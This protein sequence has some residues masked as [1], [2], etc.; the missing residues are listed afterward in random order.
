MIVDIPLGAAIKAQSNPTISS[1]DVPATVNDFEGPT[2]LISANAEPNTE[3]PV[4]GP[5][6]LDFDN[7]IT[8]PQIEEELPYIDA[9]S[10][11]ED[12]GRPENSHGG[13]DN[14]FG[15]PTFQ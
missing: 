10:Q 2:V 13:R 7:Q 15:K 12:T 8:T 11:S 14:D 1:I 9:D 6:N 5:S 4:E 3:T